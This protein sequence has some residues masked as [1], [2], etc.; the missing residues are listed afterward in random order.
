MEGTRIFQTCYHIKV[1]N[2]EVL[3]NMVWQKKGYVFVTVK[4]Q[5]PN[6]RPSKHGD[7]L[8]VCFLWS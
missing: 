8:S 5:K 2:G 6:H 3:I 4:Q 1:K 7:I